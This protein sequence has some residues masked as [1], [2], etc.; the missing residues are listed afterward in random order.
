MD[1]KIYDLIILGGGPASLSAGVYASQ[2]KLDTLL[3]EKEVFGGQIATTSSV[4]NYLGFEYITGEELS[5]KMHRHAENTSIQIT[6]EEVTKTELNGDI[7]I[8]YTHSNCYKAKA[9]IIGIGTRVRKLGV[10]NESKYLGH[11]LSY[12]TLK[13]RDNFEGKTVAIVGG[14]NSAIEDAIYLSEKCKKVY[15]VHRRQEF[16]AD[17]GV[18]D[19]LSQAIQDKGNIELV[20]DAK[21]HGI[22]GDKNIEGFEVE[23]IPTGDIRTLVVNGIFVAIGRGADTDIIDEGITRDPSGY[24]VTDTYM[25]TNISR[26]Y[27]VGDI[28]NTP[29]RQIATAVADGAIAS[30]TAFNDIRQ[31]K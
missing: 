6:H 31:S 20:L 8:V 18:L 25:R 2:M 27:A 1:N 19:S 30:V 23:H 28:R 13:D 21:P 15:I 5:E 16:R 10:P 12:T 4:T 9:V 14:G 17:K 22:I 26:V 7:K 24:I 11:G 29:L 3:I